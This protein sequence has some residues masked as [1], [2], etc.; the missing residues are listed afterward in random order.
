MNA[1]SVSSPHESTAHRVASSKGKEATYGVFRIVAEQNRTCRTKEVD[2]AVKT[3]R[4]S[5][6][7]F[8]NTVTRSFFMTRL[9]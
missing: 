8:E 4:N 5:M 6:T 7:R 9:M 1:L 2:G 3:E